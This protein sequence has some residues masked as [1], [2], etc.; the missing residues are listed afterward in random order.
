MA[1]ENQAVNTKTDASPE[2]SNDA[3]LADIIG[4]DLAKTEAPFRKP[5]ET[6]ATPEVA[7]QET[8]SET[9]EAESEKSEETSETAESESQAESKTGEEDNTAPKPKTI[10]RVKTL[11][12]KLKDKTKQLEERESELAA[13][14]QSAATKVQNLQLPEPEI[15]KEQTKAHWQTVYNQLVQ[16]GVQPDDPRCVEAVANY[17]KADKLEFF[18]EVTAEDRKKEQARTYLKGYTE[19]MIELHETT[20]FLQPTDTNVF[21]FQLN[22]ESPVTKEILSLAAKEGQTQALQKNPEVLK[23]YAQRAVL[24]VV[25]QQ[26]VG[27]DQTVDTLKRKQAE[28]EAKGIVTSGAGKAPPQAKGRDKRLD[29]LAKTAVSSGRKGDR[30]ALAEAAVMADLE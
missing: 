23:Q 5:A 21:G 24:R 22:P 26:L 2:L 8:E 6:K 15:P 1:E 7:E 16:Q 3:S 28:A 17:N 29:D 10:N 20:P 13:L 14:R 30:M 19:S 4:A 12:D 25:R 9:T 27:K 11:V 18:R